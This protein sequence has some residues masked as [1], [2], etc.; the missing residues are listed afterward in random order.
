ME[1][2][3]IYALVFCCCL[4]SSC[5]DILVATFEA[6]TLNSPPDASLP[7]APTGDAIQWHPDMTPQLKVQSSDISGSKALFYSGLAVDDPP[8]LASRWISFRGKNT[9]LTQT[10]WF[11]HTGQNMGSVILIDVADGHLNLMARMR[12]NNDGEVGL[13]TGIAD[14]YSDVIGNLD[15]GS[16][17]V[18]FTTFPARL[19]YNVTILQSS[20]RTITATEKPMITTNVLEFANPANPTLSFLQSGTSGNTYAIGSVS[21]SRK[22]P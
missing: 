19:R 8:P 12:I 13:A 10:L 1:K 9:D 15:P 7:G 14:L 4:A 16:H 17:T 3:L 2:K 6:D 22:E 20:G 11:K 18:I 5:S 21:I